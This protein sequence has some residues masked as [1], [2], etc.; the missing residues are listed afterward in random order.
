MEVKDLGDFHFQKYISSFPL[1]LSN[2]FCMRTMCFLLSGSELLLFA[3]I[4]S[5]G[6]SEVGL[7][8]SLR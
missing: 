1:F 2:P 6:S 4:K 7:T 8:S 3:K 5:E